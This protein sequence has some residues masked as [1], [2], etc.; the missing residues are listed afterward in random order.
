[1][2]ITAQQILDACK[3]T[4]RGLIL[5]SYYRDGCCSPLGQLFFCDEKV[6]HHH[7]LFPNQTFQ[8]DIE[9]WAERKYGAG[10]AKGF[11]RGVDGDTFNHLFANDE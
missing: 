7:G 4:G 9:I 5:G 11:V 1:M 3:Q 2:K 8:Q 10:Y 6:I